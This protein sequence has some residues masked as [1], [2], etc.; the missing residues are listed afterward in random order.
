[1][2]GAIM[3]PMS[4]TQQQQRLSRAVTTCVLA[5]LLASGL[6]GAAIGSPPPDMKPRL[7]DPTYESERAA[8][9]W[10]CR[11]QNPEG[12]WSSRDFTAMCEKKLGACKNDPKCTSFSDGRGDPVF[13]VGVTGLAM[14]ALVRFKLLRDDE[15]LPRFKEALARACAW[16]L[17]QQSESTDVM[18][19]GIYGG[20]HDPDAWIY[21]H[22]VATCAMAELLAHSKE[23]LELR[24]SVKA[25]TEYILEAQNTDRGWRYSFHHNPSDTSVTGWMMA[26]ISSAKMCAESEMIP[27]PVARLKDSYDGGLQWMESVTRNFKTGYQTPGDSG[28]KLPKHYPTPYPFSKKLS[29]MTAVAVNCRLLAGE[30]KNKSAIKSGIALLLSSKPEWRPYE[31]ERVSTIN[32]CYWYFGSLAISRYGDN[33]SWVEWKDALESA[34]IAFQRRLGEEDGSWDPIDEWGAIGGRVYSTAFG[35]LTLQVVAAT[36]R[37]ARK[38]DRP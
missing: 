13:D 24:P 35:A 25:A 5:T 22:A 9:E 36:H 29:T 3:Y 8:L 14:L 11:H 2:L 4:F 21:N 38:P 12:F 1:M 15:E 34:L 32:F 27:I 30:D 7:N 16:M 31:A 6:T 19:N 17:K 23:Q 18:A 20:S 10:L 37:A 33:A 26:A 28:S